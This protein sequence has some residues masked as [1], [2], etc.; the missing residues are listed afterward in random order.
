M[1][2]LIYLA[3]EIRHIDDDTKIKVESVTIVGWWLLLGLC[4]QVLWILVAQSRCGTNHDFD[5]VTTVNLSYTCIIL[6]NVGTCFVTIFFQHKVNGEYNI[7][8]KMM[9]GGQN[10]S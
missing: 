6:R 5:A 7:D 1:V 3:Y 8:M 2:G 9:T 4:N 10:I